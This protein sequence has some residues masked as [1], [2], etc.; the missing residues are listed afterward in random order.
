MSYDLKFI[1]D[2]PYDRNEY[3]NTSCPYA[4]VPPHFPILK[5]DHHEEAHIR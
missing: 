1:I 3:A 4:P 2:M 5:C